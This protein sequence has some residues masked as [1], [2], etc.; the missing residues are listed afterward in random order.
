MQLITKNI[1][2]KI[3]RIGINV[4]LATFC[5]FDILSFTKLPMLARVIERHPRDL[6]IVVEKV[7]KKLGLNIPFIN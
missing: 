2:Q 6:P 3:P 7:N 5:K 4:Q 1:I